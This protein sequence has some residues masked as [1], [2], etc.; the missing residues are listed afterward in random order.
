MKRINLKCII[1]WVLTNAY[2]HVTLHPY[3]YIEHF[4]HLSKIPCTLSK[5]ILHSQSNH[6]SIFIYQKISFPSLELHIKEVIQYILFYVQFPLLSISLR[7][8]HVIVY[9]SNLILGSIP[10]YGYTTICLSC[11]LSVSIWSSSSLGLLWI[12][13]L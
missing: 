5:S 6:F 11:F 13:L 1:W 8:M 3:Q 12:K 4:H 10:L 9:I 7:F 2:I